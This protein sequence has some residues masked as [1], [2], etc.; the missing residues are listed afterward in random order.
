MDVAGKMVAIVGPNEAG[1]TSFLKAMIHL[2][3][4]GPF[5]E[6]EI[7]RHSPRKTCVRSVLSLDDGDHGEIADLDPGRT[8]RTV[9]K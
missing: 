3:D 8:A 7:T 9:D 6:N 5:A 1:K 2:N 4:D